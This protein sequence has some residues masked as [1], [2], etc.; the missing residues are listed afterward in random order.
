MLVLLFICLC[1]PLLSCWV[2]SPNFLNDKSLHRDSSISVSVSSILHPLSIRSVTQALVHLYSSLVHPSRN[3][4]LINPSNLSFIPRNPLLMRSQK[5]LPRCGP[6]ECM[7]L[8][9][10][11]LIIHHG[12]SARIGNFNAS[13]RYP[14]TD[15]LLPKIGGLSISEWFI[16]SCGSVI[17]FRDDGHL[18]H[19][20]I[21][22]S[23]FGNILHE[24]KQIIGACRANDDYW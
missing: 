20:T 9:M 11:F 6:V 15:I 7:S 2:N 5:L 17:D 22:R 4:E 16:A 23:A 13:R 18:C 1:L 24:F 12:A 21:S 19:H 8:A 10:H 3:T 14:L